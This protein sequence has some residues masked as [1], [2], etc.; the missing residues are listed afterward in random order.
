MI[1]SH[2]FFGSTVNPIWLDQNLDKWIQL[3]LYKIR[4]LCLS[5]F[6]MAL[7]LNLIARIVSRVLWITCYRKQPYL[8]EWINL[9]RESLYFNFLD[10]ARAL[11]FFEILFNDHWN[12]F[13]ASINQWISIQS[14]LILLCFVLY[15]TTTN[16]VYFGS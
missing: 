14:P 13:R 11:I 8:I 1:N 12:R 6:V 5:C 7:I 4:G 10:F 2:Q 16:R 15:Q 3:F 9:N